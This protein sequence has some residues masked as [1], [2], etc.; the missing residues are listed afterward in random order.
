MQGRAPSP[1]HV[2]LFIP[3]RINMEIKKNTRQFYEKIPFQISVL[4]VCTHGEE[5]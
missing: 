1:L 4:Y 5:K 2:V 3:G